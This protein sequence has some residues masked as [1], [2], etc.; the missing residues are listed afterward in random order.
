MYSECSSRILLRFAAARRFIAATIPAPTSADDFRNHRR[1]RMKNIVLCADGTGNNDIKARG[2]NVFKIYEAID[3]HRHKEDPGAVPQIAFYDDGVGTSKFIPL[4]VLGGALGFGFT[5]N[6]KDLYTELAHSY[7]PQDKLF[8]F[9][10]SRGAYTVRTLAGFIQCCGILDVRKLDNQTIAKQVDAAWKVFR[11]T[12]FTASMRDDPRRA[13]VPSDKPAAKAE[14][15]EARLMTN[16]HTGLPAY[17]PVDIEFVGVWD[18]VGAIGVPIAELRKLINVF[19]PLTFNELTVGPWIKRARH[20]LSI[21]DE[22]LTFTP[23]LWNEQDGRDERIKQVWFGGVHSNV[24]GGYPKHGMSLVALDWMMSEA[25]ECGLRFLESDRGYVATHQD[26]QDKLYD[27]RESFSV[28]YRWSPRNL[29]DLCKKHRIP[30]TKIHVSVIERIA[31]GTDGYA[32]GNVPYDCDIVETRA[33]KPWLTAER[34]ARMR[35]VLKQNNPAGK[36]SPLEE[37]R[38]TVY[39]GKASQYLFLL[40][41]LGTIPAL[42][43]LARGWVSFLTVAGGFALIGLIAWI[44]AARVDAR[45]SSAYSRRWN[46][47]R[48][49]LRQ[50]LKTDDST[51]KP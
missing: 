12:A 49:T 44:W 18:T 28:Y 45:L 38:R 23:E 48:A 39:S 30:A 16:E 33:D 26:V 1:S 43:F 42:V 25:K 50:L 10:F 14:T 5:Q 21:D 36:R 24:G 13:K 40:T 7:E 6:V 4:R 19:Y 46:Q 27:S 31:N 8:L 15:E 11:K 9:G 41:T 20:A 29:A 37:M 2:T 22:R 3:R 34:I 32:P 17:S 47:H 51:S 35:E